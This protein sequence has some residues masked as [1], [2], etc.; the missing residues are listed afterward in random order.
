M[1]KK[2]TL[3]T[4][5]FFSCSLVF[6][7][8]GEPDNNAVTSAPPPLGEDAGYESFE[9]LFRLYQPYLANI[10]A[11]NPMY[12]LVGTDP[13]KTKFQISF[14]YQ[15]F[16]KQK[17]LAIKY[18]WLTGFHFGYTQTS[19]W[20][21]ASDSEAFEDTSYN[22]ELL[23][24]SSNLSYHPFNAKALFVQTGLQHDSNGRGGDQSRSSNIAY[25]KPI[26]IFY[27]QQSK[28]GL[29]IAP[30]IWA[31]FLND[32]ETNP[33][34]DDYRGYFDLQLKAGKADSFVLDTHTGW[35]REGLSFQTDLTYPLH[36]FFSDSLDIYLHV[37]YANR[38]GE[39]LLKYQRRVE[40]LR[41]GFGVVR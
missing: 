13:G 6:S 19:Y 21:L 22:P 31:Y 9:D 1:I 7:V 35:A 32:D 24:L 17:P 34:L 30:R 18:P 39:N 40:A 4:L 11:Y 15:L 28:L 38:I 23:F 36:R 10:S 8:S 25:I 20:D 5:L 2:R 26:L 12:F 14:K 29:Q 16:R 3:L 33:N 27:S 37:Q 41:I